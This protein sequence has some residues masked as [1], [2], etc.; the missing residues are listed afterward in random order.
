MLATFVHAALQFHE[1]YCHWCDGQARSRSLAEVELGTILFY[2]RIPGSEIE[3]VEVSL[4]NPDT[5]VGVGLHLT[6]NE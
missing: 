3:R 5:I 2:Q 6:S 1:D 4:L